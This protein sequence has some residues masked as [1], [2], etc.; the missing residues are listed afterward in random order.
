MHASY[1]LDKEHREPLN[2]LIRANFHAFFEAAKKHAVGNRLLIIKQGERRDKDA[3]NLAYLTP[4]GNVRWLLPYYGLASFIEDRKL[5]PEKVYAAGRDFC[6]FDSA[7]QAFWEEN[8]G[9]EEF[10]YECMAYG[11]GVN[12]GEYQAA[13]EH[14]ILE[15]LWRC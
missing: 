14:F 7:D 15:K 8:V 10:A 12:A 5:E 4:D 6:G 11:Y 1:K 13:R 9:P 2:S 3:Y